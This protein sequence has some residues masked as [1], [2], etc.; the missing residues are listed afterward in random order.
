MGG[1]QRKQKMLNM[2]ILYLEPPDIIRC[3]SYLQH[4]QGSKPTI[5]IPKLL[6]WA[7]N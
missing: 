1:A 4:T 6:T 3:K 7:S 5:G 2:Q